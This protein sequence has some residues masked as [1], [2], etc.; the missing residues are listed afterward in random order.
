M[1]EEEI[2]KEIELNKSFYNYLQEKFGEVY[3]F[4]GLSKYYSVI[5]HIN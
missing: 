2:L 3:L 4:D 1:L 5:L